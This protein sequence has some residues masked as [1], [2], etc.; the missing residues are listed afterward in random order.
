[1]TRAVVFDLDGTLID[2]LPDMTVSANTLLA[3]H[4]LPPLDRSQVAGFVGFGVRVFMNRLIAATALKASE[5]DTLLQRFM[6][7][8][9]QATDHTEVF[10]HVREALD[11][12]RDQGCVL[13]LC[14]NKPT[15][16]MKAVLAALDLAE[17]FEVAVAGDT[18]S[19]PKPDPA[20]LKLAFEKLGATE[21]VYVGDSPVDAETA[22]R[23]RVP[24]LLFSE[25]IRTV[26]L[27]EI[28]HDKLFHDFRTLPESVNALFASYPH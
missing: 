25:G 15:A 12:L 27:D 20:P 11:A 4:G 22:Q 19:V 16:P 14:T 18:L 17:Y 7:L 8:Y 21:A 2:S 10:P 13:G 28:P 23:A 5:Y 6:A 3:E 9:V 1:M 24:F 26:S